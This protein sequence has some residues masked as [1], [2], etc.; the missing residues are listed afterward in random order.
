MQYETTEKVPAHVPKYRITTVMM[1]VFSGSLTAVWLHLAN[2]YGL[3]P[4]TP[5]H[6]AL[7][8]YHIPQHIKGMITSYF[9]RIQ[10]RTKS[11]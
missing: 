2:A 10:L 9:G 3:I 8:H 7:E 4:H 6:A 1:K 11:T 5:I